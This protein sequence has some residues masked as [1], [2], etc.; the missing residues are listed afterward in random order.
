MALYLAKGG[1]S[2]NLGLKDLWLQEKG[3]PNRPPEWA[4]LADLGRPAQAHPGPVR[5][6]LALP[7]VLMYL[8]YE[9]FPLHL[10]HFDDVILTFKMEVLLE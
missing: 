10:H 7:W 9:L 1:A 8:F 5:S 3:G 6:P 4:R 2:N